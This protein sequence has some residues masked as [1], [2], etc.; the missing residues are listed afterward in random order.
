MQDAMENARRE[1]EVLY[2]TGHRP[3]PA[4]RDRRPPDRPVPRYADWHG[5]AADQCSFP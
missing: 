1:R 5:D 2:P 3:A 4:A